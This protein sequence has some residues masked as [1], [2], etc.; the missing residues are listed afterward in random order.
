VEHHAINL[1]AGRRVI[2][3]WHINNVNGYHGRLKNWLR[4]FNGVASSYLNHYLGWFR[5]LDRFKPDDL[6][7]SAFLACR[8]APEGIITQRELSRM[9]DL[10]WPTRSVKLEACVR[11]PWTGG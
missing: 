2:G 1:S 3:P 7:P 11:F 10:G 8:S 6:T 4:R 9:E 5:S